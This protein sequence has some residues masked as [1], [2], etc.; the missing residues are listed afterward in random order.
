[1]KISIG[2]RER[3]W[4]SFASTEKSEVWGHLHFRIG[5]ELVSDPNEQI[6]VT[7]FEKGLQRS[8]RHCGHRTLD[9]HEKGWPEVWFD[10][11]VSCW[12]GYERH[13]IEKAEWYSVFNFAE[14]CFDSFRIFLVEEPDQGTETYLLGPSERS[15]DETTED[16]LRKVQTYTLPYGSYKDFVEAF[17]REL[18]R[19]GLGT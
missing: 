1:M 3:L 14:E 4:L 12:A 5:G 19:L 17:S 16:N 8:L 15:P 10:L 13:P 2:D 11:R 9:Y 7:R 6:L 18:Q